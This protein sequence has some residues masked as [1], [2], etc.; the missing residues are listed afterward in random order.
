MDA[1]AELYVHSVRRTVF[2]PIIHTHS[3][4]V[5]EIVSGFRHDNQNDN[6]IALILDKNVEKDG[7]ECGVMTTRL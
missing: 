3:L 6:L 5:F 4:I 7:A 1:G 2:W